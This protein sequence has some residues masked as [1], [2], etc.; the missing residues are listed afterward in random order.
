MQK[1]GVFEGKTLEEEKAN[2]I[3]DKRMQ[4]ITFREFEGK[5]LTPF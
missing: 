4:E 3:V 2:A 1:T 5:S